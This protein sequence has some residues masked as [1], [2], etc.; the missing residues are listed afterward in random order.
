MDKRR[1]PR[2]QRQVSCQLQKWTPAAILNCQNTAGPKLPGERP[3]DRAWIRQEL[4]YKSTH[5]RI[6]R[7]AARNAAYFGF[8]KADV[9]EPALRGAGFGFSD[10]VG[11]VVDAD[12]HSGGTD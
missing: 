1:T 8:H 3:H 11:V 5:D 7:F 4:E 6:Q 2:P 10:Y 9:P 12:D